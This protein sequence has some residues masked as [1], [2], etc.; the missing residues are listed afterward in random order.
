MHVGG[1]LRGKKRGRD[2]KEGKEAVVLRGGE[3]RSEYPAHLERDCTKKR[4]GNKKWKD[5]VGGR[6]W[7]NRRRPKNGAKLRGDQSRARGDMTGS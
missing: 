7:W 6:G 3:P 5:E 1:E 4:G 2:G